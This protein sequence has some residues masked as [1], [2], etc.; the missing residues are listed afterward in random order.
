MK[1]ARLEDGALHIRDVPIPEPGFEEALIRISAAGICHSD[2]HLARG[3]WFGIG[4]VGVHRPRGHRH[5]RGAR[6]R[7]PTRTCRSAIG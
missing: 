2:L 1:A 3:D 5:R 6:P 4:G 7:A